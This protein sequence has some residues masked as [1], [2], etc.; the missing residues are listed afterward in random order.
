M[1]RRG[2]A[3]G[4]RTA[5]RS[6]RGDRP[7]RRPGP[8]DQQWRQA[9][10]R[11]AW[12]HQAPARRLLHRGRRRRADRLLRPAVRPQALPQRG[13][14]L[15]PASPRGGGN[16]AG[17]R[18]MRG[19]RPA[20]PTAGRERR[21]ARHRR[22]GGRRFHPARRAPLG[23]IGFYRRGKRLRPRSA[24]P[25]NMGMGLAHVRRRLQLR[26]GEDAA[27]SAGPSDG[28][29]RVALRLPCE[30]PMAASSRA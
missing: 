8:R 2:C 22:P 23:R 5:P 13:G 30:S 21:Q 20:A 7:G 28:V 11:R 17:L 16:R 9:L 15:R 26:Y 14:R 1:G 10:L 18:N 27:F 29:Y 25:H 4:P 6:E 3:A 24:A 19:P 12:P